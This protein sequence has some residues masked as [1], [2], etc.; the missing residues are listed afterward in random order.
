MEENGS[1]RSMRSRARGRARGRGRARAG[2]GRTKK[3]VK[4]NQC[5]EIYHKILC[6]KINI[7]TLVR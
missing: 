7:N 1:K 3:A 4:V 2:R 6:S 5:F